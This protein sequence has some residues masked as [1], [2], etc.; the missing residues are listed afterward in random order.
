MATTYTVYLFF[1][2]G[3]GVAAEWRYPTTTST[4]GVGHTSSNPLELEPGDNVKFVEVTGSNG[5][6]NV[7]GLSIFTDN[8]NF[9]YSGAD[10]IGEV[11]DRT[12]S[13]GTTPSSVNTIR[14]TAGLNTSVF[15]EFHFRRVAPPATIVAPTSTSVTLNNPSNLTY[16][17]TFNLSNAGSEG[18]YE[19]AIEQGDS[20]PDNWA[21]MPSDTALSV[22]ANFTRVSNPGI[23]Y[24]QARRS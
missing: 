4:T 15:D 3:K 13:S 5:G 22:T 14:A 21:P 23:I 10:G 18:T 1:G 11:A 20:S 6:G 8:N 7:T 19:Y 16:T 9:S 2:A 17:A 12:V 24:A